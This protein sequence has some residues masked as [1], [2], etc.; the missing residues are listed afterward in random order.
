M[1]RP[2]QNHDDSHLLVLVSA[3]VIVAAL[4][5]AKVV[6][7]PF[8]LAILFTFILTPPVR[9]AGAHSI[10]ATACR[11]D[12]GFVGDGR[13]RLGGLGGHEPTGGRDDPVAEIQNEHQK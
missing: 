3:V 5:F 10:A 7:V 12:G 13:D 8:A 9:V 2:R 1:A 6:L 11:V 4:Y